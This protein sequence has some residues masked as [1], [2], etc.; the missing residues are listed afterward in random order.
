MSW[1]RTHGG[2]RF[3][4]PPPSAFLPPGEVDTPEKLFQHDRLLRDNS[5]HVGG[6]ASYPLPQFDVFGSFV[7]YAH[8]TDSHSGHVVTFGV[9]FP[10]EKPFHMNFRRPAAYL[11][12]CA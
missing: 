12:L 9:S 2:L 10:F 8:G 7:R 5:F 6:G 4:P 11:G 3:G 1:Q